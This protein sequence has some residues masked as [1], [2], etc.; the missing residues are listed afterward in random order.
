MTTNRPTF[1]LRV[2]TIGN[3]SIDIG[4]YLSD[5]YDDVGQASVELPPLIEWI[6]QNLQEAIEQKIVAKQRIAE[7]EAEAFF[8][9][10][11]GEFSRL[12]GSKQTQAAL[13]KA[14]CL[15]DAVKFAHRD[16]AAMSGWVSRLT[17][18]QFSLNTKLELVRSTEATRRR[19]ID[20]EHNQD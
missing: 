10:Q 14:V 5:T 12:Y 13:E 4:A 15:D 3:S 7:E 16:Y 9:L 2:L 6:N 18:V 1:D 19:L 8:R 17:N 11:G 20:N